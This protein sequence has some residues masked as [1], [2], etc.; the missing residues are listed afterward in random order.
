M[1]V[2]HASAPLFC[3][4]NLAESLPKGGK[5][6]VAPFGE[7]ENYVAPFGEREK[8][9]GALRKDARESVPAFSL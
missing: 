1:S 6:C 3:L 9:C 4:S 2:L 5:N 7:Q 8:L